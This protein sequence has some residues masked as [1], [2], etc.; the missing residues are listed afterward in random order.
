MPIRLVLQIG[1]QMIP[2]RPRL[3]ILAEGARGDD[4]QNIGVRVGVRPFKIRV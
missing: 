3:G 4:H 1:L 2:N